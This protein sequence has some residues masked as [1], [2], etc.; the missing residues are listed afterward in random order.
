MIALGKGAFHTGSSGILAPKLCCLLA[1]PRRLDRLVLLARPNAHGTGTAFGLGTV[2]LS[3]ADATIIGMKPNDQHVVPVSILCS[4]PGATQFA[5]WTGG[6]LGLPIQA[7]LGDRNPIRRAGLPGRV[8]NDRSH[9]P[10]VVVG[11]TTHQ[12]LGVDIADVQIMLA[13]KQVLGGQIRMDGRRQIAIGS[14]RRRGSYVS[15]QVGRVIIT[16][17]GYVRLVAN[18]AGVA[19]GLV[20][21]LRIIGRADNLRGWWLLSR[22][23]LP[24]ERG[25]RVVTS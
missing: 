16:G 13:R 10:H 24:D 19:L 22:G 2:S 17:S 25:G 14:R 15:D 7:E 20:A 5:F 4:I 18:P 6:L 11:L 21:R 12:Q 3:W 9:Q 1:C 8:A 23:S